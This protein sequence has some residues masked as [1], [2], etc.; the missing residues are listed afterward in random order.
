MTLVYIYA[1]IAW[2]LAVFA[3]FLPKQEQEI[4][5]EITNIA[6]MWLAIG[7]FILAGKVK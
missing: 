7:M 4:K 2:V 1:I 5:N 6:I 3:W